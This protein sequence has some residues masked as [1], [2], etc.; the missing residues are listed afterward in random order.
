[1]KSM[2]CTDMLGSQNIKENGHEF[3]EGFADYLDNVVLQ[4]RW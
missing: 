2:C 1:M 3:K 4:M